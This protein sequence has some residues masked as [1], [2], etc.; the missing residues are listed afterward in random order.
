MHPRNG[1]NSVK[2]KVKQWI[3]TGVVKYVQVPSNY[4]RTVILG[5][6]LLSL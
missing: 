4:L 3:F 2:G 5:D 1:I 6:R